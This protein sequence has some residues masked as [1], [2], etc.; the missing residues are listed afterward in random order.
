ME[1]AVQEKAGG[2]W[3]GRSPPPPICISFQAELL[4]LLRFTSQYVVL[5]P[6]EDFSFLSL[7]LFVLF[8]HLK[9]FRVAFSFMC[10][11]GSIRAGSLQFKRGRVGGAQRPCPLIRL[12]ISLSEAFSFVTLLLFLLL[13]PLK[14]ATS[15]SVLVVFS[16]I[17]AVWIAFRGIFLSDCF[18]IFT[19]NPPSSVFVWRILLRF[20]WSCATSQQFGFAGRSF[21]SLPTLRVSSTDG[22][23]SAPAF[24]SLSLSLSLLFLPNSCLGLALSRN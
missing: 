11:G 4:L 19:F 17:T 2:G 12:V 13:T 21:E 9:R 7:L 14:R 6:S 10:D 23:V 5:S 22:V 20:V 8:T 16:N 3:G 1:F 18:C 15:A 24:F